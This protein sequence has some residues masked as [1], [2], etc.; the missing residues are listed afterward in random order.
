[1]PAKPLHHDRNRYFSWIGIAGVVCG[2]SLVSQ[3]SVASTI[4]V[5]CISSNL[6][7]TD[8]TITIPS[9]VL[10]RPNTYDFRFS[11]SFS[12]NAITTIFAHA[13]RF[14]S[15][16]EQVMQYQLYSGAPGAGTFLGQSTMDFG[17]SI[18]FNPSPGPYYIEITPRQI[19]RSGEVVSGMIAT[20]SAV[21]EPDAWALMALG[22][23]GLG[24]I[25]RSRRE[26]T[27]ASLTRAPGRLT[28]RG[29]AAWPVSS[30]P[31]GARLDL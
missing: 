10:M 11:P 3:P 18:A 17:P 6:T 29:H 13:T 20:A 25:M 5:D 2:I 1:L 26:L 28:P 15:G 31:R 16:A 27:L 12:S 21:P 8:S 30:R 4:I 22:V 9:T 19:A 23:L 7:S 24:M 14:P